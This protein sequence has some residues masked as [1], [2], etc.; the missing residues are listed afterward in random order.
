MPWKNFDYVHYLNNHELQRSQFL[1]PLYEAVEN[2]FQSLDDNVLGSA[3]VTVI[4][5]RKQDQ[6]TMTFGSDGDRIASAPEIESVEVIDDG[7]GFT[8]ENWTAFETI[9]TSHR[10]TLGGKGMGRL[11]FCVPFKHV[12]ISSTYDDNGK[13]RKRTFTISA[14]RVQGTSAAVAV[15]VSAKVD[16]KTVVKFEKPTAEMKK[17]F[18]KSAD[19]LA[20]R[21][22]KHFFKRLS[23]GFA[24]SFVVID[25]WK[26][27]TVDVAAMCRDEFILQQTTETVKILGREY[28]LTHVRLRKDVGKRHEVLICG[29]G[30]VVCE[31]D[32]GPSL[33]WLRR[34]IS[35]SDG[36]F[37][38]A[39][40][41]E[42]RV[43]DKALR[44]DRL[45]FNLPE[46]LETQEDNLP[47]EENPDKPSLAWL[48]NEVA[49][50]AEIFLRDYV[51]PLKDQHLKRIEDFCNRNPMYR[52]VLTHRKDE[53]LKIQVH[54]SD[55][56]F[57]EAVG[58][59]YHRWKSQTK[60]RFQNLSAS[61]RQN[62]S[63][64]A[65]Y[66]S[67]YREALK[68][69]NELAFYELAEYV[70][71]RK[72]VI[73]FLW[74]RMKQA[75]NGKFADEDAVHDV[76]FPRKTTTSEIDWD[77][78][79]LWL[80][81]ERLMLQNFVASDLP[82]SQH[83]PLDTQADDR[84]DVAIY[85][86]TAFDPAYAF[87]EGQ[88]TTFG[89]ITIVEFKR[90]GRDNY[91]EEANP[92]RQVI[93]YIRK[94]RSAKARQI[95]GHMIRISDGSP[96]HVY[97]VCHI[98]ETLIDHMGEY[99]YIK[100]QDGQGILMHVPHLNAFIQ[101]VTFEKLIEDAR[102]RH[103]SFFRKLG[104]PEF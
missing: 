19:V 34:A 48:A 70:V 71:D 73:D 46:E 30:R 62:L 20:R 13:R 26:D 8:D 33:M 11:L 89:A 69:L 79:Q 64:Q 42:G 83:P 24:G 59:I 10:K 87:G 84:P 7:V 72:A 6:S 41:L 86:D 97:V 99:Q 90:P 35:H 3:H 54:L 101:V 68:E 81:D 5:H 94:I 65:E 78:S 43:L 56:Q 88:P 1:Q 15:D 82:M 103:E 74:D 28:T 27:E 58:L 45:S 91:N 77:E 21:F 60:L 29:N 50:K 95:D 32:L 37:Y 31:K 85:H 2:A 23:M 92:I 38:Y 55:E 4:V 104:L 96:I 61:A 52:P 25:K 76:F 51:A 80:I 16:R 12:D 53:L 98:G 36:P 18:P 44:D 66:S 57:A 102:R 9:S 100:T 39:G 14:K 17:T 22:V 49:R 40:I 47:Y 75:D 63:D 93:R 67:T